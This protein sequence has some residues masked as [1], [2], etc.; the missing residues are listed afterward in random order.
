MIRPPRGNLANVAQAA[1]HDRL[2]A[3]RESEAGGPRPLPIIAGTGRGWGP[4]APPFP[5]KG[6]FPKGWNTNPLPQDMARKNPCVSR[7][8][9]G[10]KK[11]LGKKKGG[12]FP[13]RQVSMKDME[14]QPRAR[15]GRAPKV[16]GGGQNC[17]L[18]AENPRFGPDQAG[19]G[20]PPG[21]VKR[22]GVAGPKGGSGKPLGPR[23]Y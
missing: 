6:G 12:F 1:A 21:W 4:E 15:E 11:R 7:T 22:E 17:G 2:P 3:L 13:K 5:G 9:P 20:G 18:E 16:L 23:R 14:A 19:G 8:P 10:G